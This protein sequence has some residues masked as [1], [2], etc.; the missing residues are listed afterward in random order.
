MTAICG[1]GTSGPNVGT[2]AVVLVGSGVIATML[3]QSG[4]LWLAFAAALLTLPELVLTTF[5]ATDPPAM[6]TFTSA[7]SAALLNVTFGSDLTSGLSKFADLVK[8]LAWQEYCQCTSGALVVPPPVAPPAGTPI[9]QPPTS[10]VRPCTAVQ[11]FSSLSGLG[12]GAFYRGGADVP[13]GVNPSGFLYHCVATPSGTGTPGTCDWLFEQVD[14][15]NAFLSSVTISMG[16]P[17]QTTDRFVNASP[18][19]KSVNFTQTRVSGT[20]GQV[21]AGTTISAYC[22]GDQPGA[23][24]QPCCPPD[25]ATQS[26][27]DLILK[28]TTLIQRQI[29]PFAYVA[30]TAHT[31]ISGNGQLAVSGLLGVAVT[32]TTLPGRAGRVSGDPQS[33][34]EVGWINLGTSDGWGPRHFISSSSF[35]LRPVPGDVTLIGYSIPTDT[36]VTITEL[37]REP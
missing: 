16:Q 32:V 23:I 19:V 17:T 5:C 18:G 25:T 21:V 20:L 26:T 10:T 29:A 8:N 30:G 34:W 13:F 35:L 36:T 4:N 7:E 1:G 15:S 22:N 2:S 37:I 14:A 3:E 31:G 6:P 27:L 11:Q 9:Y 28:M 33:V 12:V 24:A